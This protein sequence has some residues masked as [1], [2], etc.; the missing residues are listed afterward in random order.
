V[1]QKPPAHPKARI[2]PLLALT[3]LAAALLRLGDGP[4]AALAQDAV[5]SAPDTPPEALPTAPREGADW[6]I[7]LAQREAEITQREA[8]LAQRLAEV[9]EIEA[10]ITE[11]LAALAQAEAELAATM[12]LADR[13]AEG[14]LGRLV[15]MYEN[16]RPED[17]ARL[18][19]EMDEQ[20]A[21]GFLARLRPEVAAGVLSGMEPQRAY[22]I[23]AIV[24]GRNATVPRQ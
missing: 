4:I 2:L 23:S 9:S 10:R 14:D 24:A 20:F 8:N 19:T 5:V 7:R 11:H 12:A 18:F 17:A 21:A 6:A 13:A 22:L 3:F 15:A 16:M 1:R